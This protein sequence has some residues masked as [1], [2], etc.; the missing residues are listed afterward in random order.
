MLKERTF[1]TLCC[2]VLFKK[3]QHTFIVEDV[4]KYDKEIMTRD[5]INACVKAI[6][7]NFAKHGQKSATLIKFTSQSHIVTSQ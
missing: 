6:T 5:N 3:I 4:S 2:R 7:Y 1:K